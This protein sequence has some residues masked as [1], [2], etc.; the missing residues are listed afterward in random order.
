MCLSLYRQQSTF[1]KQ[2]LLIH[3][4]ISSSSFCSDDK[5]HKF[6][7]MVSDSDEE[8]PNSEGTLTEIIDEEPSKSAR[9]V[10]LPKHR[11][12]V[13]K[14]AEN[15]KGCSG[16]IPEEIVEINAQGDLLVEEEEKKP[17][18]EEL[19]YS[20]EYYILHREEILSKKREKREEA[21]FGDFP[22]QLVKRP[23]KGFLWGLG[24]E[25]YE[26]YRNLFEK[27][28]LPTIKQVVKFLELHQAKDISVVNVK[29][30]NKPALPDF[31]IICTGFSSRH[32]HRIA[33]NLVHEVKKLKCPE[34]INQPRVLGRK[35]DS[36]LMVEV[37]E[38]AVHIFL[39][40]YRNEIDLEYRWNTP[41]SEE[42]LEEYRETV[43]MR[44]KKK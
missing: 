37:K 17:G 36:W 43:N 23:E 25:L 40:D 20:Q 39:E 22:E 10:R 9:K 11:K 29:E 33:V 18:E 27:G 31:A 24:A 12:I 13:N 5:L 42:V 3:K 32:I 44:R 38:I 1:F 14:R 41:I 19:T 7:K 35:E 2:G 15:N 8:K 30:L 21:K 34:I 26:D 6:E 28:K 16:G 4:N